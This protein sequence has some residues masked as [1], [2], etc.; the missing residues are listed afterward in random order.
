MSRKSSSTVLTFSEQ[1][2]LEE[3][4]M[5]FDNNIAPWRSAAAESHL[6][7]R[8]AEL[9]TERKEGVVVDNEENARQAA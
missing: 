3:I 7:N 9:R 2:T 1:R 5:I 6:Q 4:D 8:A